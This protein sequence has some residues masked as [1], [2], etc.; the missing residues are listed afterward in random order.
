LVRTHAFSI[1]LAHEVSVLDIRV[2][3][4][5]KALVAGIVRGAPDHVSF[6]VAYRPYVE[7]NEHVIVSL[8]T[9]FFVDVHIGLGAESW[10]IV[11]VG[12]KP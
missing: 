6:H 1:P 2:E 9:K 10:D 5:V 8:S 4:T 3:D 7:A 12:A 11:D